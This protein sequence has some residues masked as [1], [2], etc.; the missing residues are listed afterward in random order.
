MSSLPDSPGAPG[1]QQVHPSPL[2]PA[3]PEAMLLRQ[4]W[5]PPGCGSRSRC[6]VPTGSPGL[7]PRTALAGPFRG[8]LFG[9]AMVRV[10]VSVLARVSVRSLFPAR[11]MVP[12]SSHAV[13]IPLPVP[14]PSSVP[15]PLD[16]AVSVRVRAPVRVSFS[17]TG[18]G[19]TGPR[20]IFHGPIPVPARKR[21]EGNNQPQVSQAGGQAQGPGGGSSPV[22][23]RTC[24]P[25]VRR[26]RTCPWPPGGGRGASRGLGGGSGMVERWRAGS[27]FLLK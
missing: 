19:L 16:V 9:C 8:S 22:R 6:C 20:S 5:A 17:R 4:L 25:A 7:R 21:S 11:P 18:A 27:G 24:P 2:Q 3:A 15:R 13:T 12:V 14:V 23:T 26:G 1:P 10:P